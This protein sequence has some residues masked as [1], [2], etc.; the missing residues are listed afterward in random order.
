MKPFQDVTEL[1]GERIISNRESSIR[2]ATVLRAVSGAPYSRFSI[3]RRL[4]ESSASGERTSVSGRPSPGC[5][6]SCA[7][8]PRA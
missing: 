6:R 4:R 2:S 7:Q 8:S 3:R 5:C 1:K